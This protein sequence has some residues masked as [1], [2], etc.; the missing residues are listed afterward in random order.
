LPWALVDIN[1]IPNPHLLF[2]LASEAV[3]TY[4]APLSQPKSEIAR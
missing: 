2:A 1:G 3:R 4:T